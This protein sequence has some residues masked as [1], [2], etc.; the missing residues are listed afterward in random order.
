MDLTLEVEPRQRLAGIKGFMVP[1]S[2]CKS[3]SQQP[4]GPAENGSVCAALAGLKKKK[5]K[6]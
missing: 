2:W 5:K 1:A 4:T 6:G 3:S